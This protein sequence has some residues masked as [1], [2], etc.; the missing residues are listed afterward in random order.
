VLVVARVPLEELGGQAQAV[1]QISERI[2]HVPTG[3]RQVLQL[4][5]HGAREEADDREV[6]ARVARPHQ[7]LHRQRHLLGG[8]EAAL[9]AH[10]PAHVEQQDGRAAGGEIGVEDLEVVRPQLERYA[11]RAPQRLL[12]GAHQIEIEGVAVLIRPGGVGADF[13][14]ATVVRLMAA[15]AVAQQPLIDV[16]QRQLADL[17]DP[18]G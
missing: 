12:Q 10:R 4:Q 8:G 16:P 14:E 3:F 17:A 15:R 1:L 18:L 5:F 11:A 9:P 7:A 2:A 13:G 6:V